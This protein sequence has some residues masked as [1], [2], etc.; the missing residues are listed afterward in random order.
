MDAHPHRVQSI[1][2]PASLVLEEVKGFAAVLALSTLHPFVSSPLPVVARPRAQE[3]GA[4]LVG[5]HR[6]EARMMGAAVALTG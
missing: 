3:K 2:A 4:R 6:G 1:L 5:D